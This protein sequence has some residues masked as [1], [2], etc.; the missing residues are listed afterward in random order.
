MTTGESAADRDVDRVD[1]QAAFPVATAAPV[2]PAV[3]VPDA[4]S[5]TF[6]EVLTTAD[7]LA[8]GTASSR[9]RVTFD[10]EGIEIDSGGS[11]PPDA[12]RWADVRGVW[13]GLPMAP[14]TGGVATPIDVV[15]VGGS[16]RLLLPGDRKRTVRIAALED[17]LYTWSPPPPTGPPGPPG[18]GG[19]PASLHPAPDGSAPAGSAPAPVPPPP[20]APYG[21]PPPPWYPVVHA[22]RAPS[23]SRGRRWGALVIG[24][25]LI[26][27]GVGVTVGLWGP[28]RQRP[29]AGRESARPVSADQRL[30]DQIMLTARDLPVGWRVDRSVSSAAGSSQLRDGGAA[31]TSTFASCMGISDAQAAVVFGGRASDQTAQAS[32]PIFVAPSSATRPG[33]A[34][35]FQTAASIVRTGHDERVDLVPFSDPRY[36]GCAADATASELQLG[37]NDSS[38]G[39][40]LPGPATGTLE[41]LPAPDGEQLTALSVAF[42]V[43]DRSVQVPVQVVS[44]VLGSDRIEGQLEAFAIGGA[45]PADVLQSSVTAFEAR[46]ATRGTG[47]QI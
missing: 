3:T 28:Q 19:G 16:A 26:A 18:A 43:S 7:S 30:A 15:W 21:P 38:G 46:V 44:V 27:A 40:G 36:R 22:P 45:I 31:T 12:V 25:V 11:G 29:P 14:P 35:E 34:L 23:R 39:H 4:D 2:A 24:V 37:V 13:F 5:F 41:V 1:Q 10:T 8:P 20:V 17:R 32:S 9:T 47:V 33:F 6:E 42:T